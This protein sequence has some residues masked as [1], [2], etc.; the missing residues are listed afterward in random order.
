LTVRIEQDY[1]CGMITQ[2]CDPI[3]IALDVERD[4]IV[5]TL[6]DLAKW[7]ETAPRERFMDCATW[8]VGVLDP[9]ARTIEHG[10]GPRAT[11]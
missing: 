4:R 5:H 9:L 10:L 8:I 11:V 1:P 7:L 3:D 6:R 2:D